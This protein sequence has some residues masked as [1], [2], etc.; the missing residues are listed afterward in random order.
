MTPRP[1]G[2][3]LLLTKRDNSKGVTVYANIFD[4]SQRG[5]HDPS[6]NMLVDEKEPRCHDLPCMNRLKQTETK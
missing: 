1:L 3:I 5:H 6:K 2:L 4:E